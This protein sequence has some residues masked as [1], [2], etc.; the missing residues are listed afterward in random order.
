MLATVAGL[1]IGFFPVGPGGPL[2][3]LVVVIP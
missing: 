3:D 1:E 2:Y